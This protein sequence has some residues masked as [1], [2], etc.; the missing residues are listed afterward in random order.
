MI[1]TL[2]EFEDAI[3]KGYKPKFTIRYGWLLVNPETPTLKVSVLLSSVC[4][5]YNRYGKIE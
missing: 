3:T 2:S 5:D 1:K 4:A